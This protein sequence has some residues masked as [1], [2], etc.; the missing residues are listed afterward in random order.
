MAIA[1]EQGAVT[2]VANARSIQRLALSI[3]LTV[4][5]VIVFVALT[6]SALFKP[7]IMDEMEFPSVAR[8]IME[9][10]QPIYYR[11]ETLPANVGLWHPPLYILA[12]GLWNLA[13]GT[14]V[15]SVRFYGVFNALVSLMLVGWFV[16]RRWRAEPLERADLL[17]GATAFGLGL[18]IAATSPLYLQGSTLPDIDTQVLPLTMTAMFLLLFELRRHQVRSWIYWSVF[19]T[20]FVLQL[21][22]KLTTPLLIVPVFII[23]ELARGLERSIQLRIAFRKSR[24]PSTPRALRIFLKVSGKIVETLTQT[25]LV[26]VASLAS[27]LAFAVIWYMGASAWGVDANI[28]FSYLTQSTNNPANFS[29]GESVV[30]VMLRGIPEHFAYIEQ[31]IGW[32][33]IAFFGLMLVREL[34]H[35][36]AGIL[37]SAERKAL[38]T[39][40]FLLGMMYLLLRPAPFLFPKYYPP[41]LIPLA[42]LALD[43]LFAVAREARGGQTLGITT[44]IFIVYLAYANLRPSMSGQDYILLYY[45]TWPRQVLVTLWMVFPLTIALIGS[46]LFALVRHTRLL[47]ALAA[48]ALAISL[49]WQVNTAVLQARATYSTTYYYGEESL[50]QVAEYLRSTLPENAIIIAPKDVGFRI[51]DRWG[52]IELDPDPRQ[53]FEM[54]GV[55]FL[56]LRSNDYYGHSVLDVPEV[57]SEVERLFERV[58]TIQNFVVF[59][60]K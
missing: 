16:Y 26:V 12:Y 46:G 28:P 44:G 8:A 37:V 58:A 7:L 60:R 6:Y 2:E 25:L 11:G 57:A 22:A 23:F 17:K 4:L 15:E 34:F 14:S 31:W 35:P 53:E 52:Y 21:F 5:A 45:N 10:G 9:T 59:Q 19:V 51:Q 49:G 43:L 47:S 36:Q 27:L 41:L 3:I 40:I 13:F 48:T 38:Y 30:T 55:N 54:P 29:G 50:I 56:V 32:P 1:V 42:I 33:I 20:I 24:G 39:F 18:A